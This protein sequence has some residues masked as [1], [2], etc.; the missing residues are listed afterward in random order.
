[1]IACCYS[2]ALYSNQVYFTLERK[3]D[4]CYS[5][6]TRIVD[7]VEQLPEYTP[8]TPVFIVGDFSAGNYPVA[9]PEAQDG[10]PYSVGIGE[11]SEFYYMKGYWGT[12][13]TF[14]A[15]YLGIR[16]P[17][18]D[19]KTVSELVEETNDSLAY[20]YFQPKKCFV[21]KWGDC[22]RRFGQLTDVARHF[23]RATRSFNKRYARSKRKGN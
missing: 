7:R 2:W 5:L 9:V 17:T 4:A 18:P 23:S 20:P 11:P 13:Q 22:C 14:I 16:W 21:S 3:F 12:V 19:A 10:L 15:A 1:M 6:A 8:E